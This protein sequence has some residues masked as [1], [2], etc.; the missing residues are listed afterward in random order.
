MQLTDK[1]KPK[2][3]D[4]FAG[5]TRAKSIMKHLAKAPYPS[6]WL[7]TGDSGTGKTTLALAVAEEINAQVIH[8]P[9]SECT[10]ERVRALRDNCFQC[11]MFGDWNLV[12]I[13]E[14]D[15]MSPAAQVAFLSLLDATSFPPNTIFIFT[16]NA[17]KSFENR[18]LSRCRVIEFDGGADSLDAANFL[19]NVWYRETGGKIGNAPNMRD[20]IVN[21]GGNVRGAL[22][23]LELELICSAVAA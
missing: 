6:A 2:T 18:F 10:I 7:F 19:F 8:I 14:A 3:I 21:N 1:Y 9:S 4:G 12:L 5:L 22:M 15:R 20:L 11:P 23:A 17:V 16:C 13:D